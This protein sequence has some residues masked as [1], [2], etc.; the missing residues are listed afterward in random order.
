[1]TLQIEKATGTGF[2][3]GVKRA[4]DIIEKIARESGQIETLRPVV[5]NRQVMQRLADIGVKVS[6]SIDEIQGNTVAISAHGVSPQVEEEIRKRNIDI[7]NLTCSFVHRAQIASRR[8][9]RSGFFVI[10]YGDADHPEVQGILGWAGGKGLATMDGKC[11]S[12]IKHLPRRLGILSQ[13]TQ[14]PAYFAEFV[15]KL[16]DYTL[17]KDAEL[18]IIDTICHDIRERQQETLEL[19]SR[20][21][22][23]LVIGSR[24]SANT[25]HLTELCTTITRTYQVE[26]AHE[27]Q[28]SWFKGNEHVGITSGT[29]TAEETINEVIEKLKVL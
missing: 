4:I 29:S 10:I 26:T 3:F 7:I 15:K 5:H 27:I 25:N 21:D 8:L 6:N 1:M 11:V 14:I 20:V 28:P 17:T 19:A 12:S 23:I 18:R 13:T 24:H 22:L 9:A 16:I 2:C